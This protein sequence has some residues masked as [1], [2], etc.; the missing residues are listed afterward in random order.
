MGSTQGCPP[1]VSPSALFSTAPRELRPAHLNDGARGTHSST[2]TCTSCTL[3]QYLISPSSPLFIISWTSS[4]KLPNARSP[5]SLDRYVSFFRLADPQRH[6]HRPL[7][8][9]SAIT[10]QGISCDPDSGSQAASPLSPMRHRLART[11]ETKVEPCQVTGADRV[12]AAHHLAA[13]LARA[14]IK[15]P[16]AAAHQVSSSTSTI[17]HGGRAS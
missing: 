15:K 17:F 11:A 12:T 7:R 5:L 6:I 4:A 14:R 2:P 13:P 9:P 3:R 8:D 10:S 1:G 16:G